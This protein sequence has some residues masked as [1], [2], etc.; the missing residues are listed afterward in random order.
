VKRGDAHPE[1]GTYPDQ[2]KLL[3]AITPDNKS[4]QK[5]PGDTPGGSTPS[6]TTPSGTP[7]GAVIA[8]PSW[9]R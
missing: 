1:G 8:R 4:W 6:G 5:P 9:G 2:N 3:E 7:S